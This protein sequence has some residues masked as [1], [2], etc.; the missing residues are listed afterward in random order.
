MM[1][2]MTY[3]VDSPVHLSFNQISTNPAAMLRIS[4]PVSHILT[5][6][7]K[8]ALSDFVAKW[9]WENIRA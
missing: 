5:Q 6:H 7:I 4:E 3:A 1:Q 2:L 9:D 8:F